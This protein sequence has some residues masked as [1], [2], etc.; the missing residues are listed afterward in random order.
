MVMGPECDMWRLNLPY[1]VSTVRTASRED[2]EGKEG[3]YN[4][5][6]VRDSERFFNILEL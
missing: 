3:T 5:S 6:W 2:E 4:R 1:I